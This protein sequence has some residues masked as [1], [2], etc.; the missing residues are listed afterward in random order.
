MT[1]TLVLK[2]WFDVVDFD[3][4]GGGDYT[5]TDVDWTEFKSEPELLKYLQDNISDGVEDKLLRYKTIKEYADAY[6]FQVYER[7]Y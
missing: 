7:V 1:K 4:D 3:Y 2:R 5:Y 6:G